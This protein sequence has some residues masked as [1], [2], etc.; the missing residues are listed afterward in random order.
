MNAVVEIISPSMLASI[1]DLG[2]AGFRRIGVP[3]S[4]AL[5]P[6]ALRIA[7]HLAGNPDDWPGI[8]FFGGGLAL[9]AIDAPVCIGLA[10]NFPN[11]WRSRLLAP[12]ET[13]RSGVIEP[14]RVGYVAIAGLAVEKWLGSA[15]TYAR[16][17]LGALL[18]SGARLT[19]APS[20][21][22]DWLLP[23][24]SPVQTGPIRVVLGPQEDFF[25]LD[26]ITTFLSAEFETT[27]ESDRMG[28]R[29]AGPLLQHREEKGCEITSDATLPGSIQVPGNGRPIVLL[30]DG[31]TAGGYPKIATVISAD[32]P[33]LACSVPG[34]RFRFTAITP[35]EGVEL[36]KQREKETIALLDSIRLAPPEGGI[37]LNALYTANLVDGIFS[38]DP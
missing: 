6:Q 13:F 7:N 31:Q 28:M 1:Q 30:A 19:C 17:G 21:R 20:Q 25:T 26:S 4:G 24:P 10:G 16:A 36:A 22:E 9:R 29:L 35:E 8:E 27:Q 37:D 12:G 34:T 38:H 32:L 2:R 5:D 23:G 15:S 14:G 18:A 11:S 3:S 33:R